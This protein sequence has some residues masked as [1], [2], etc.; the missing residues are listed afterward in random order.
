[1]HSVYSVKATGGQG[2][3]SICNPSIQ[4]SSI[5][6]KKAYDYEGRAREE[7][8]E[9]RKGDKWLERWHEDRE[10]KRK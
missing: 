5:V 1:M 8:R 7:W 6:V 10:V 2:F 4:R 9:E 3:R